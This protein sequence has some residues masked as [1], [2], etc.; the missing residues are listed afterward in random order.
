MAHV[1]CL[2]IADF[3]PELYQALLSQA[4]PQRRERAEKCLRYADALRCLC[5]EAL[6]RLVLRSRLPG[7][8]PEIAR[9]GWGKPF[10][11][12]LPEFAFNLSHSGNW[13]VLAWGDSPV[14]VDVET[15]TPGRE[16]L[17]QRFFSP[18]EQAWVFSSPEGAARRFTQVWTAKESYVK[19]L[20]TGLTTSLPSFCTRTMSSP[21][22]FT[23]TLED[24]AV[25]TLCTQEADW[26][27][28]FLTPRQL[29]YL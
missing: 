22:F 18:A 28:G 16:R 6:L 7:Q 27:V 8:I 25:L 26:E 20:G 4:S 9:E 23:R 21:R 2:N 5:G 24:G 14:G 29:L 13:V 10:V 17:A 19:F 1:I 15:V 12:Q 3:P 11:R